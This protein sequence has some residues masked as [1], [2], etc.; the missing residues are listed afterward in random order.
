MRQTFGLPDSPALQPSAVPSELQSPSHIVP[1][2]F[3]TPGVMLPSWQSRGARAELFVDFTAIVI[4]H[5]DG[6]RRLLAAL[7]ASP[8]P[9]GGL[10]L[11]SIA[12]RDR[13]RAR[14]SRRPAARPPPVD[15]HR[16]WLVVLPT[17]AVRRHGLPWRAPHTAWWSTRWQC[18]RAR[19]GRGSGPGWV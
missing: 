17:R 2:S 1:A 5:E 13:C 8:A 18:A 14:C 4:L 10:P 3:H 7:A 15:P 6:G 19:H 16:P 11:L 9:S 12:H